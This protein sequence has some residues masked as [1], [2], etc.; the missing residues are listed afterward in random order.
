MNK[1]ALIIF[2]K[3]PELGKAKTRLAKTM[4][5]E[6]ALEVY[7]ELLGYTRIVAKSVNE[8]RFVY[9]SSF[10]DDEDKWDTQNF[11]NRLQKGID[12]GERMNNAFKE[13]FEQGFENVCIIG[14][15]CLEITKHHIE[16][17]FINLKNNDFVFGPSTDGGY[18]LLGMNNYEKFVFEGKQWSTATLLAKTTQEIEEKGKKYHLLQQ[19]TDIDTEE[20]LI[21][22]KRM[23]L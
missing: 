2:I 8:T 13:V 6:K 20:D 18:Y 10:I 14:S 22:Q 19:L 1:N 11:Q 17:A 23:P 3:N 4:G 7:K 21:N 5:D 12:L 16:Q 15:D 9:Y